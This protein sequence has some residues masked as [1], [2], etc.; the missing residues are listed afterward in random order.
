VF[1]SPNGLPSDPSA[2]RREF[3]AVVNSAGLGG[4]WTPNMLR[5][6]AASLLSDAGVPLE[7]IAD[8]LGHKDT[9]MASLHYRH[10]IRPTIG[11]GTVMAGL[12]RAAE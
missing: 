2:V 10:R 7:T 3:I 9:R 11:A 8:Q 6:T 4:G 12:L 1:T 5:H